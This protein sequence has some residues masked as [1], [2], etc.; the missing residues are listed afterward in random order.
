MT[1]HYQLELE[2]WIEFQKNYLL[3]SRKFSRTRKINTALLPAVFLIF[4]LADLSRGEFNLFTFITYL[5]ISVFWVLFMWNFMLNRSL[6]NM[7]R[8]L[9]EGD[10]SAVLGPQEISLSAEGLVIRN[11]ESETRMSWKTV[12]KL[13]QTDQYYFLYISSISAVILPKRHLQEHREEIDLLIKN[14]VHAR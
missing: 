9:R 1:I 8:M 2:D 7:R 3:Q 5:I 12:K 14:N 13:S 11:S 10:N 6:E 4:I